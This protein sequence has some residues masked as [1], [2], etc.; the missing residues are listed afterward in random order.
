MHVTGALGEYLEVLSSSAD[1]DLIT[2][3]YRK[4]SYV[5]LKKKEFVNHTKSKSYISS[6]YSK[7]SCNPNLNLLVFP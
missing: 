7:H 1:T 6:Q 2:V 4:V 3:T 5:Y